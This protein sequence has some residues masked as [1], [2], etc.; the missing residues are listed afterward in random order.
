MCIFLRR[1]LTLIVLVSFVI[2]PFQPSWGQTGTDEPVAATATPSEAAPEETEF[3]LDAIR[4]RILEA[5]ATLTEIREQKKTEEIID[6]DDVSGR[7]IAVRESLTSDREKLENRIV[8]LNN[9][10][11][12]RTAPQSSANDASSVDPDASTSDEDGVDTEEDVDASES[13]EIVAELR[14]ELEAINATENDLARA[15]AS[16]GELSGQIFRERRIVEFRRSV[17][18]NQ[19]EI[20]QVRALVLGDTE[21]QRLVQLRE[22]LRTLKLDIARQ[23]DPVR[24]SREALAADLERIGPPPGDD[25]PREAA[26]IADE[27]ETLTKSLAE[28]DAII[29]Q[30]ELNSAEA[31]RLLLRIDALRRDEFYTQIFRRVPSPI[32]IDMISS[33]ARTFQLGLRQ[34]EIKAQAWVLSKRATASFY[35]S[36]V[37]ITLSLV[38]AVIVFG[39]TRRWM[40]QQILK[41]LETREPTDGRKAI[42]ALVRIA[43]RAIPG[44]VGGA[45]V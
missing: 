2:S 26:E 21:G 32:S 41:G 16:A 35:R 15:L 22:Q 17:E 44:V 36:V 37:A 43:S 40:N 6:Y 30:S 13:E 34:A 20:D 14:R 11:D 29:R 19:V 23:I 24:E 4:T 5:E 1:P 42:A 45:I 10:V 33:S 18:E 7:I 9:E 39:P 12:A 3:D 25:A 27:R 31:D 28:E 38:V 8:F